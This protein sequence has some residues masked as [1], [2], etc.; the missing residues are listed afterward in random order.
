MYH[1]NGDLHDV[2]RLP[3]GC[4]SQIMKLSTTQE[5]WQIHKLMKIYMYK[6]LTLLKFYNIWLKIP[7]FLLLIL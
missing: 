7:V 3:K 5:N 4:L 2:D 6:Y 1:N